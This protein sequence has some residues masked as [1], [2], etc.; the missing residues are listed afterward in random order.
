MKQNNTGTSV[1]QHGIAG[2]ELVQIRVNFDYMYGIQSKLVCEV[3]EGRLSTIF[4]G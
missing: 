2:P 4:I 1:L 3:H